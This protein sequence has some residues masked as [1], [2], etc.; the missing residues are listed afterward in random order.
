MKQHGVRRIENNRQITPHDLGQNFTQIGFF[1]GN[2]FPGNQF[3][4]E[5][6][7]REISAAIRCENTFQFGE[8]YFVD[9]TKLRFKTRFRRRFADLALNGEEAAAVASL[10]DGSRM[11]LGTL[12]V[13]IGRPLA[14]TEKMMRGLEAK[15]IVAIAMA[16]PRAETAASAG[17]S[18]APGSSSASG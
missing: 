16:P 7:A 2:I 18:P 15:R 3:E 8:I 5:I 12:A 6:K 14:E 17:R 13:L 9:V 1:F 10:R 11:P 4:P